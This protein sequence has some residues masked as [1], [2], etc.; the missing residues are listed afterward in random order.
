MT[1]AFYLTRPKAETE[2]SIFARISYSGFKFKYYI[3]EKI[4][5]KFWN[6]D[7][8]RAKETQRFK[9]FPEFN[10]RLNNIERDIR[11]PIRKYVND[12]EGTIPNTA[13]LKFLLDKEIKKIEPVRE[14]ADTFFLCRCVL[15][16]F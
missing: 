4:N 9:E 11:N 14:H 6:S 2:T 10:T 7:T 5:P 13:T 12:N 15:F 16:L 3:P 8:Q 1:I